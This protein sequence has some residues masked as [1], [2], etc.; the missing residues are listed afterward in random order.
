MKLLP[1]HKD[2]YKVAKLQKCIYELKQSLR[3]WYGRLTTY[4]KKLGFVSAHF[5]PCVFIHKTEELIISVYINNLGFYRSSQSR[6]TDLIKDLKK[7]FKITDLEE[8]I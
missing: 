3:K 5:D 8:M 2:P 6:I 1:E 4:L 7:E